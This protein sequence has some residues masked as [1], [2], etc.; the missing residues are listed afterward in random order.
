MNTK[1]LA[2]HL[3]PYLLQCGYSRG[4]LVQNVEVS[5]GHRSQIPLT[6]FA[7]Y[8][9]DSRS[10]CIAVLEGGLDPKAAVRACRDLGAPL[11]FTCQPDQLLFWKQT[12]TGPQ[13]ERRPIPLAEVAQFFQEQ[14][15][16][17]A[18]EAVYRAKTWARFDKN[19][20][21]SFVD[22]GLMPLVEEEAGIRLSELI[23]RVVRGA[24]SRLGW[25]EVSQ[26][27]GRWLLQSNFWLLAAK[28]LKDKNVPA[29]ASLD[30]EDLDGVYATV[31]S[32]YGSA[33]PVPV[34]PRQQRLALRESAQEIAR[35]S[36][37]G[38][39]SSE[40]LAY[41]YERALITKATRTALGTHSTPGYL[42]EYIVGK[43]LPWIKEMPATQRQVFEPACGHAAFLPAAMRLLGEL[44][45][46]NTYSPA[47]RHQYMRHRLHGNDQDHFA[48]EIARL[49]LTL[50]DEP[51]SNGWDLPLANVFRGD[52]LAGYAREADIVLANPPFGDFKRKERGLLASQSAAPKYV[53]KAAELL[54]RIVKEMKPG[55]VFGVVLPQSFLRDPNAASLRQ[56][57]ATSFQIKEILLLPDKVF[58]ISKAE[59]TVILGRRLDVSKSHSQILYRGVREAEAQEFKQAYLSTQDKIIQP[60]RFSEENQWSFFV[61]DLE[62]VWD[63]C[64]EHPKFNDVAE[65]GKGL[66]FLARSD[67]SFPKG[68]ITESPT[69]QPGLEESFARLHPSLQTHQLPRVSW[70]NLDPS[71][72]G[73]PRRG[74]AK[75]ISQVLLNYAP[76]GPRAWR[77][78][79]FLDR[80]GHPF[81]T[82]FLCIRPKSKSWPI[83]A[84]WGI[85]NSPFANAYAYA[86]TSKRDI[87][88]GVMLEMPVPQGD[89]RDLT[90]LVST[91]RD[92]L[93]AV[94]TLEDC[95]FPLEDSDK[96]KLLHWR[97]D[98]EALRLY[99]LP[100]QLEWQLLNLFSG[101]KRRGVPFEQ[102]GYFPKGLSEPLT[103]RDLLAITADWEQTNERRA[104]L[105]LKK[106]KKS[107]S[108][109]GRIELD[110]LQRLADCRIRLLA[111]LPI[112]KLEAIKEDLER[113][114]MWEEN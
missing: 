64:K 57:I 61:P 108:A 96:L 81:T 39:V 93:Q 28:I 111:P 59:S 44:P 97:I 99:N 69:W 74:T 104:Q 101:E 29:F 110:E 46:V 8:P 40:A 49:S 56:Y 24:K 16:N 43:L 25:K 67:P 112:Q 5:N 70:F 80:Q 34:G 12:V 95:R 85:C 102:D 72:I 53:N 106:V 3:R 11:V 89:R 2:A 30:L 35:F 58:T 77:I 78:K 100:P 87:P 73:R 19:Y 71:V 31:A 26:E 50:A 38:L 94:Q 48:L 4:Q 1:L 65:I 42:V 27:Q 62:E 52:V 20:Q 60:S 103:L 41:L 86:Y 33:T 76:V 63:F 47:Q 90:P 83:E 55:A 22:L 15:P 10:A 36:H 66:E 75:G 13:L 98:A 114:G 9:H 84:L 79:A 51:N 7:H 82:R 54:W 113:R 107:I 68:A 14:G 109:E 6:A 91:V 17:L 92:Y 88:S 32:H 105:I 21:L 37:L 18:P 23:E 45:P